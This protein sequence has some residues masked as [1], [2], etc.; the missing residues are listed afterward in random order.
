MVDFS[1]LK[2]RRGSKNTELMEKMDKLSGATTYQQDERLYKPTFDKKEKM[3]YAVV[4]FLPSR[5]GDALVKK[6]S[7]NFKC[8]NGFYNETSRATI[9]EKDPV[10]ISNGLYWAKAE[11]EGNESL[12]NIAKQRKR[13]T[14]FYA[15]V[16][17]IKDK[18]G[19]ENEG[20]VKIM[21]FGKQIFDKIS[22]AIKPKF[23][24][25]KPIDPFDL[26]E[27]K[28]FIIRMEGREMPDSKG[29]MIVV[30]NYES[31][32]FADVVSELFDGNDEKKEEVFN[33][34]YD[35]SEFL[36][37]KEFDELADIFLKRTGE[38][39]NALE[40]GADPGDSV[41]NELMKQMDKAKEMTKS[42][43]PELAQTS[44]VQDHEEPESESYE[45]DEDD[46]V[47][48]QFKKFAN[49]G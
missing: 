2:S 30:P 7:H 27:G 26:W 32:K 38:A 45:D 12:K 29:N 34:T 28:D 10:G 39:Y 3:G 23:E 19:P 22:A 11:A 44:K 31:S 14:E 47:L 8:K 9:G 33:K 5:E 46:D 4:R 48:A 18:F 43:E 41:R 37:V 24:D 21:R 25:D 1:K 42:S 13:N 35:L 17:V 49:G 15:N 40:N 36:K 6:I 16:Y 20:Q